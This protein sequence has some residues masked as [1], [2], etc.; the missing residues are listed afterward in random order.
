MLDWL[1]QL[2]EQSQRASSTRVLT[3]KSVEFTCLILGNAVLT[4]TVTP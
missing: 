4:T 1:A 2:T 3:A